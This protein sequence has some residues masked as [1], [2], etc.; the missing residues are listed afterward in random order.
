MLRYISIFLLIVLSFS[1]KSFS[2]FNVGVSG[3][4][5]S[6]SY[7]GV[8][9]SNAS[10][11]SV[12]GFGGSLI[13][14]IRLV[15]NV[16]L[17]LQPGY[18]TKGSKV[19]FGN[20]NNIINDT[21]VTFDISQSYFNIPLNVKIFS[22]RF[23]IAAGFAYQILSSANI[24]NDRSSD[25]KDIKSQFKTFDLVSNF[26]VGYQLPIGTPYLFFELSYMQGLVNINNTNTAG[27][28]DIYLQNFKSKGMSFITGLIY[29]IK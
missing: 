25:E 19:K 10:Y 17:S 29:P 24:T 3:E 26:N 13:G 9:P 22:N 28:N 11:E 15:K 21:T 14:E 23:Y 1:N 16:Y 12:T 27:A 5:S 2:Q 20:E 4:L 7:G 6:S 8:S 18:I